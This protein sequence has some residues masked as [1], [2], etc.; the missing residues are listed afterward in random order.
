M[1]GKENGFRTE[2]DDAVKFLMN[3]E[4]QDEVKELKKQLVAK[5]S[6]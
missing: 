4:K 6:I 3:P 5:R 1:G 2:K